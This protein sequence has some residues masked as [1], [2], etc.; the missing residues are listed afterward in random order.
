MLLEMVVHGVLLLFGDATNAA[1]IMSDLILS[2]LE[3]HRISCWV[4]GPFPQLDASIFVGELLVWGL[5]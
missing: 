2:V 4:C 1:D 3:N 5:R